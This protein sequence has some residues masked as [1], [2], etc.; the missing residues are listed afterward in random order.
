ME[1]EL[2]QKQIEEIREAYLKDKLSIENQVVKLMMI[3]HTELRAEYL[4]NKVINEYKEDLL[5]KTEEDQ[6]NEYEKNIA[7][8][9]VLFCSVFGV[10]F[11]IKNPAWDLF[12]VIVAAV[13]GYLGYNTK[14]LAGMVRSI[15]LAASFPLAFNFFFEKRESFMY[16]ELLLPL[17]ICF[18]V[19]Y[20][21]QIVVSKI[22][23]PEYD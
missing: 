22:F 2:S 16:V 17:G 10:V 4:V 1:N 15:V 12:A 23:Y 20:L 11:G 8:V 14:P 13:A 21:F 3:G 5:R 7:D 6:N 18:V 19:A 9:V